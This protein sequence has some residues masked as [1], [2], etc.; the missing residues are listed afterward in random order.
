MRIGA[1]AD[2]VV[3]VFVGTAFG[4]VGTAFGSRFKVP[5]KVPVEMPV[6]REASV[7]RIDV[8][9]GGISPGS[10]THAAGYI[11]FHRSGRLK[12]SHGSRLFKGEGPTGEDNAAR[13]AGPPTG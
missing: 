12:T 4:A 9:T 2:A 6:G 13:A 8:R 7:D 11:R 10:C 5:A 3:E 1:L